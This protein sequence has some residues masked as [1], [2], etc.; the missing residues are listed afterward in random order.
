MPQRLAKRVLLVGWDAADWHMIDPLLDKGEMPA[1]AHVLQNGVRAPIRT[2]HPIISPILWN[3]IATGKRADK[4]DIFGF[5]EP[6]GRGGLRPVSSTSRKAKAIWNILSQSGLKSNIV[7]W[8]ASCPAEQINGV[9]V[10]DLY[11]LSVGEDP[12]RYV[13][14]ERAIWPQRLIEPLSELI[15]NPEDI[16][17]DTAKFFA[18][19][20][21]SVNPDENPYPRSLAKLIAECATIHNA[22]TYL[23]EHEPFDF[24]A[25]YYP[26]IDHFAHAFMEFHPP[27][28]EHATEE[29]ARLWGGVM[30]ACYR[31]HDLMLARLMQLAGEDTT[32][33]VMSDH[34]FHSGPLRPRIV[35]HPETKA[36][37]G[38]GMNP[39]A[40]HRTFGM[41]AATGPG[42]R[43][44]AEINGVTLLDI[45]PTVLTLLGLPV[46]EDMDGSALTQMFEQPPEVKTI[47]TWEGEHPEDGVFRGEMAEDTYSLAE[48]MRQLVELG[49]ISEPSTDTQKLTDSVMK[50]RK[51]AMS[52][53]A[54]SAGRY[55]EAEKLLRELLELGPN[56][57]YTSRLAMILMHQERFDEAQKLLEDLAGDPA[58]APLATLMMGQVEAGR[59]DYD[60]AAEYIERVITFGVRFPSM[61][62][63]LGQV[64]LRQ[65]RWADA[66]KAFEQ[67]LAIDPDDSDA[68]DGLGVALRNQGNA[69]Q[70][71]YFHMKSIT[72]D[73]ERAVAHLNLGLALLDLDQLDWA[74]RAIET[75][76]KLAPTA[77]QP[78]RLLAKVYA[79]AKKDPDRA[80]EHSE[81]ALELQA[82]VAASMEK[83]IAERGYW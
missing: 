6:D 79:H 40:W 14:D 23:L 25:V 61:H 42:I 47:P 52:Q 76:A 70:A 33:I 73:A 18:P 24:M 10:G 53:F 63:Q 9:V 34:G 49:Y 8:Y 54:F 74:I 59:G 50:D 5:V 29:Q 2:L 60:K 71:V 67:A 26:S 32:I 3:S 46:G 27:A 77:P 56:P 55:Q 48:A 66:Q 75:S 38:A 20:I 31:Y 30:N 21:E 28:M 69:D 80:R 72:L 22:A 39:V 82:E 43:K 1:L 44:G 35:V 62:A 19:E 36:R 41:I 17:L 81:R 65:G 78:H 7:G 11:Q 12:D 58:E 83:R 15:L 68:L 37:A 45:C 16:T 13:V 57:R 51:A 64:R 4:H